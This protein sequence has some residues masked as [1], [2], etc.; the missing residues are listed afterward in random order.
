VSG[1]AFQ[2]LVGD[3]AGAR[4]SAS[5]VVYGAGMATG[6]PSDATRAY[7][8]D[9]GTP[10]SVVALGTLVKG[11]AITLV[12]PWLGMDFSSRPA[13]P[14][15]TASGPDPSG[16]WSVG[17]TGVETAKILVQ[18]DGS[19]LPGEAAFARACRIATAS[20]PT[21]VTASVNGRPPFWS[22][23][24]PLSETASP[25][26]LAEEL[27][28]ALAADPAAEGFDLTI[29]S[30]TPGVVAVT[31]DAGRDLAV[32]RTAAAAWAGQPSTDVELRSLEPTVVRLAFPTEDPGPWDVTALDVSSSGA[33]PAWRARSGQ[34]T[35]DPGPLGMRVNATFAVARR[36]VMGEATELFGVA[37]PL[38]P[39]GDEAKLHVE[40]VAEEDDGPGSGA[41]LAQTDLDLAPDRADGDPAWSEVLFPRSVPLVAGR[42]VWVV[43]KAR[44]GAVE[45][46]SAPEDA[47]AG[48]R[49]LVSNQGGR[50]D[51]YPTVAGL[52][53]VAQVRLLRRPAPDEND[54]L[55]QVR[56]TD[57]A[58]TALA[59]N[60]G[61]DQVSSTLARP[62]DEPLAV[63][64]VAGTASIEVSVVAG[65]SGT[66]SLVAVTA[67]YREAGG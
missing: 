12:L 24:G 19:G 45:W 38:R 46:A 31:F 5:R 44:T 43:A 9:F 63:P 41:P 27:N 60:P 1:S 6:P 61:R 48:L 62:D 57:G 37:L 67:R 35:V 42:A 47:D 26:G 11:A 66:L 14:G 22:K 64:V 29:G 39:P 54:P 20:L 7:V 2:G 32:D 25:T 51:R 65:A 33:F 18:L 58:G 56:W 17:L 50:W 13:Y 16:S 30:T 23:P 21:N 3:L 34:P 59:L 15:G 28:A 4:V 52:P 55:L 53:P 8:V 36:V 49:T 40:V 10:V